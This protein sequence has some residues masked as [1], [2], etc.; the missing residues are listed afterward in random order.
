MNCYEKCSRLRD[1]Y[2]TLDTN[3]KALCKIEILKQLIKVAFEG[4]DTL[5]VSNEFIIKIDLLPGYEFSL[6]DL[7]NLVQTVLNDLEYTKYV[8]K[9]ADSY[10]RV[11]A[12]DGH[13]INVYILS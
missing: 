4:N 5:P 11:S 6:T 1:I 12:L 2:R 9:M 7:L 10:L 13:F 8:I 3:P